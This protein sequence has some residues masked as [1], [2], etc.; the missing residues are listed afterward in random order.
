[1]PHYFLV[2][3]LGIIVG[4]PNKFLMTTICGFDPWFHSEYSAVEVGG[5]VPLILKLSFRFLF[6][7]KN[8]SVIPTVEWTSKKV[9]V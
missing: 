9:L 1:M 4:R 3:L 2:S 6:Q 8:P 5:F 7:N